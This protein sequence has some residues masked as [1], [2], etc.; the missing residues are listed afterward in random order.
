MSTTKIAY[1]QKHK[2][3]D[4]DDYNNYDE[5]YHDDNNTLNNDNDNIHDDDF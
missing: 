2:D 5:N 3:K 4:I 1:C